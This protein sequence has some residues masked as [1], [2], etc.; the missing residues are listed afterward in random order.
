EERKD[1]APP[2]RPSFLPL[3]GF[4]PRTPEQNGEEHGELQK[5]KGPEPPDAPPKTGTHLQ[6]PL[7]SVALDDEK[8]SAVCLLF[9]LVQRTTGAVTDS[10]A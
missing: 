3:R 7:R 1:P 8:G 2:A 4:F 5:G 10:V 9:F 6:G